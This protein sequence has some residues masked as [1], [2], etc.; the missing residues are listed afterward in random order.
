LGKNS[1]QMVG[2]FERLRVSR[3]TLAWFLAISLV[4]IALTSLS[5]LVLTYSTEFLGSQQYGLPLVWK[6]HLE[7]GCGGGGPLDV[8]CGSFSITTYQWEYFIFDTLLYSGIGFAVLLGMRRLSLFA[9]IFIP[10][11]ATWIAWAIA[12]FVSGPS[13]PGT[14]TNGL[15]IPWVGL[16]YDGWTYSWLGFTIDV[17]VFAGLEYFV[18]F[19]YRG[20]KITVSHGQV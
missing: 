17:G 12:F 11:S 13:Q 18:F 19:I 9:G 4:A 5:S 7:R 3:S 20:F 16:F 8:L 15:P 1:N 14:W 6:T 10:V 2:L